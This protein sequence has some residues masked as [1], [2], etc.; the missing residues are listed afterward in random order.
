MKITQV[1]SIVAATAL[2]LTVSPAFAASKTVTL[3]VPTMDCEVCPI[4]VKKALNKVKGV[5][6]ID[7][8]PEKQIVVAT[9][10]DTQTNAAALTETTKN[11]GYPSQVVEARQ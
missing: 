5:T 2:S 6:R 1:L 7:V 3:S 10:D 9:F 11:A 4:T 8:N